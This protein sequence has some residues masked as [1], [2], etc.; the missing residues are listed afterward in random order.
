[1]AKV[2]STVTR[3]LMHP[4]K[5]QAMLLDELVQSTYQ[6]YCFVLDGLEAK[7]W[8]INDSNMLKVVDTDIR[9]DWIDNRPQGLC[10][11]VMMKYVHR[12]ACH[13]WLDT[14]WSRRLFLQ[15][16]EQHAD[17]FYMPASGHKIEKGSTLYIA[18]V[19]YVLVDPVELP[20]RMH[21]IIG[22]KEDN[23]WFAEIRTACS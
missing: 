11:M 12:E 23:K 20:G 15:L 17:R 18:G 13:N 10:P 1:M 16:K 2:A 7:R 14:L 9:K 21:L 5:Q 3:T 4:T 19:G 8:K 6:T 22:H